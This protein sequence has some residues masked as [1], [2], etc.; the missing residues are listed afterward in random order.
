MWQHLGEEY[1]PNDTDK[2]LKFQLERDIKKLIEVKGSFKE[3]SQKF[4]S[5]RRNDPVYIQMS[6]GPSQSFECM[7]NP[8]KFNDAIML[9]IYS[10][11]SCTE[12]RFSRSYQSLHRDQLERNI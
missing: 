1:A 6:S 10:S 9:N 7:T 2:I 12:R 5:L 3:R 11:K 4:V 8:V